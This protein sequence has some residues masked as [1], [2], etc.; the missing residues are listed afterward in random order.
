MGMV[1]RTGGFPGAERYVPAKSAGLPLLRRA[2]NECH[3]CDLYKR[4]TQ[5][6]FGEMVAGKGAKPT[7]A[8]MFVGEQPGDQED[9]QGR[10]FVGPA[11]R[12]LDQAL[13]EARIDRTQAYVTNAVKHFKWTPAPRG[14]RRLHAK[15]TVAQ[16]RACLPWLEREVALV[17][18]RVIVCLGATAAQALLGNLFRVTKDRGKPLPAPPGFGNEKMRV[19]AT[20]HPSS[21]LR[22]PDR[23]SR[24]R[25]YREFV[26]DLLAAAALIEGRSAVGAGDRARSA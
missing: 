6:V 18:P 5:A 9:Q 1:A 22:A 8:V 2:A 19:L 23:E 25:A 20:V 14:K 12:I 7:A 21:I 26:N 10:P 13:A 17:R 11:G 15:P 3:G 4:A 24:E 16:V